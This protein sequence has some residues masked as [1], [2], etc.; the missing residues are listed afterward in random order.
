[1]KSNAQTPKEYLETLPDDRKKVISKLRNTIK[2][3]LPKGFKE[4]IGYGMLGYVVPHTTYPQG[5]HC[6]PKLPLPF[7]NI[8]SQKNFISIYHMGLY[9]KELLKWL[10]TNWKKS[11]PKKLDIGK[12]CIRFKNEQ[13][14]PFELIAGLVKKLSPK[15]W[16][17]IYE[18]QFKRK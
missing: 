8:A 5:Y 16:I 6:N 14:I 3:N 2:K 10:N 17:A 7:I 12:C 18:S 4:V 15:E 1:M 11:S 9:D 13:D